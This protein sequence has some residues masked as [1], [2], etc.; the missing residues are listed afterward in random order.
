MSSGAGEEDE[1]E[2]RNLEK[3]DWQIPG[4]CSYECC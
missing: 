2:K 4:K 1:V 3:C